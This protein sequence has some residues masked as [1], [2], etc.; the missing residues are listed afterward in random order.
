MK[1]LIPMLCVAA[2]ATLAT[3]DVP[4]LIHY[5]GRLTDG[6]GA[7]VTGT[8]TLA[9]SIHDAATSGNLL[10]SEAIGPVTLDANG[11]YSFQFG[12]TGTSNTS[13]TETV[14]TTDGTATTYQKVF[15]NSPVVAGTVS[16][17]DGTYTWSQASGSSNEDDFGV[18]YSTSLRRVTVTYFNGPPAAGRTITATYR[19]GTTGISGAL[20]S[21]TEHWLTLTVDGTPQA[22][23]Q[24]VLAVPF[25]MRADKVLNPP[26]VMPRIS[27]AVNGTA[28]ADGYLIA[29]PYA[30][31]NPSW[32]VTFTTIITRTTGQTEDY[33]RNTP[34]SG[35]PADSITIP[36]NQ[37]DQW[38]GLVGPA[39]FLARE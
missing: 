38:T 37:G 26:K 6:S 8:K 21:A 5:Q 15:P 33:I 30:Q 39:F 35:H 14:A 36:V 27:V 23:R 17:T 24:R 31:P 28:P 19:Y 4:S 34:A 2:T 13:A 18:S 12:A 22:T 25:A 7:P 16:V 9:I 1:R 29:G 11:V 20:A 10:Y 3:A 32:P